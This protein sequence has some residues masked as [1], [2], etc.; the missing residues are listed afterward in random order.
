[1]K[2]KESLC[3]ILFL[4]ISFSIF[5]V[6]VCHGKN[7]KMMKK[8][9]EEEEEVGGESKKRKIVVVCIVLLLSPFL[10]RGKIHRRGR[11]PFLIVRVELQYLRGERKERYDGSEILHHDHV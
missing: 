2:K 1:M 4:S 3:C 7:V 5:L 6:V 10:L 11:G 9:E 8:R